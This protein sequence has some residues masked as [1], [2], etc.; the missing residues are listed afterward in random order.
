MLHDIYDP[1]P[2]PVPLAPPSA[3][4]LIWTAPDLAFLILLGSAVSAV[5]AWAFMIEPALAL[6]T[7]AGGALVI[8][9]SW[10]S[11]LSFLHRRPWVGFAGR[12][13][14]FVAALLPWVLGLGLAVALMLLLFSL[15]DRAG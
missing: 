11:A 7:F 6:L 14:V 8:C 12:W 9:E 15:S 2:A 13:K 10:F 3:E 1:P 5:S 4:P